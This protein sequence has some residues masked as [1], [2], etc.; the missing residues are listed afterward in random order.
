MVNVPDITITS[1]ETITGFDT[2]TGNLKFILDELQNAEIQNTQDT[3]DIT[4]K[5]GRKLSTLKRNKAVTVS[6]TN[7]MISAG[8]LEVQTGSEFENKATEVLWADY[9]TVDENAAT[10]SYKAIGTT[11]AEIEELY[12]R[13]ADGSLGTQLEIVG[14]ALIKES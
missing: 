9:L 8:L 3:Q 11:G 12:V 6:G 14:K 1:L 7:G 4:G 5:G 2:V 10:T 13:N